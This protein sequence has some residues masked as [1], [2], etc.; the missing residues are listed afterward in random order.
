M[1]LMAY[2]RTRFLTETPRAAERRLLTEITADLIAARDNTGRGAASMDALHRNREVWSV[3]AASC[4]ATGN[5]LPKTLRAAIISLAL[6]VDKHTSSVVTGQEAIE[7]LISVNL[8]LIDG[9]AATPVGA[10][11]N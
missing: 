9:L 10:L 4:G 11:K 7:D 5:E 6:W 1:S 3:F 2:T 8:A